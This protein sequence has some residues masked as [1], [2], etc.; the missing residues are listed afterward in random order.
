[1]TSFVQDQT[2]SRRLIHYIRN[3][4]IAK[5]DL[6]VASELM[7]D[8]VSNILAG[9]NSDIGARLTS[10]AKRN[11]FFGTAEN[12]SRDA[13]R[14]AFIMGSLSNILEMDDL[15][16]G[17]V[18]HPG[19]SVVPA[20]LGLNSVSN[21]RGLFSGTEALEALLHGFE[22]ATRVG[23]AVGSEHYKIWQNTATCGPFGSAM[24]AAHLLG[25]DD[26]ATAAALGNA[27][28]QSAGLWEFQ[29]S[30]AM[31]K[32]LHAGRGAEAGTVAA[33]LAAFGFT[34]APEIFEGDKGFFRAMCPGG[35][36]EQILSGPSEPWQVHL[37]SIKPW[38]SCRHT[39]PAITTALT[40]RTQ[41][42]ERG[43]DA[44]AIDRIEIGAYQVALDMCDQPGPTSVVEAKFSLQHCVAA[45]LCLPDV[46]F[47]I[48]EAKARGSVAP[49]R[50]R[51]VVGLSKDHDSA[52]PTAWGN[53]LDVFLKN[54]QCLHASTD[55]AAGDLELPL[56]R[57]GL[58]DK[59][60][61]LLD[62]AGVDEPESLIESVFAMAE[63][64]PIPVL[65]FSDCLKTLSKA[66][67][68]DFGAV[69]IKGSL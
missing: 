14:R 67:V 1:M 7:L 58:I 51:I 26:D 32:H 43:L 40:I 48:L 41:L 68:P 11:G 63:G 45:A 46:D 24:A 9:V 36:P 22:A 20:I 28:T 23:R 21:S 62:H 25:L 30:G 6:I 29:K 59:A 57:D 35:S 38:P 55:H 18:V 13:G 19:C 44:E 39:H 34:G 15:H 50:A 42:A 4:K 5:Q 2:V 49:L 27:G 3:K 31:S 64:G 17:S 61:M 53:R 54:G 16:R 12:R 56:G 60:R 69:P 66:G 37:T 10:W 33:E 52:Y 47:S 8:V 65:P